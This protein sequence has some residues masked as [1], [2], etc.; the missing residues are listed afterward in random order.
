MELERARRTIFTMGLAAAMLAK[1]CST[2]AA[3]LLVLPV[4]VAD[5][6]QL[7]RERQRQ[8]YDLGKLTGHM[9]KDIGMTPGTAAAEIGKPFWRP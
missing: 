1:A 9:L 2:A 7:W 5:Q 6:L 4:R 3:S 8:R